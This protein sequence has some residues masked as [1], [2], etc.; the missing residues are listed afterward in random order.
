MKI[1][2]SV[3]AIGLFVIMA[4]SQAQEV[5]GNITINKTSEAR[6]ELRDPYVVNLFKAFKKGDYE[7]IFF[8]E[9]E[10]YPPQQGK[11]E[12]NFFQFKTTVKRNGKTLETLLREPMPYIPGGMFL[13]AETFDFIHILSTYQQKGTSYAENNGVIPEGNYEI[14]LEAIPVDVKEM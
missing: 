13:A 9:A 4:S 11:P 6:L 14:I 12:F 7:L 8:F 5:S 10:D 1:L 2:R 3:L